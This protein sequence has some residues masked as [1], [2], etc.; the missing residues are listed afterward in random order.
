MVRF[1]TT[2]GMKNRRVDGAKLRDLRVRRQ[3]RQKDVAERVK[4]RRDTL[5]NIEA[6][7][8]QPSDML[9]Y[10]LA[11]ALE[12]EVEDFVADEPAPSAEVAA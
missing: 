3:L 12:C 9:A 5:C 7:R 10:R 2:W 4:V 1:G 8:S 6:G 11:D